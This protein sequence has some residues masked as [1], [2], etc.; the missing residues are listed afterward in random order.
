MWISEL[1]FPHL[2]AERE[3]RLTR[4]LEQRRV[5]LERLDEAT[6]RPAR[7]PTRSIRETSG[8]RMPRAGVAAAGARA[9]DACTT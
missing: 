6:A 8:E 4:E 1:T 3:A 9:A 7:R 5:V 2:L